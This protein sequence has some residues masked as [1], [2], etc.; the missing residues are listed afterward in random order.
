MWL[1]SLLHCTA[2]HF[3]A[4]SQKLL[5]VIVVCSK[6]NTALPRNVTCPIGDENNRLY[7]FFVLGPFCH[8]PT[9]E[10]NCREY[11]KQFLKLIKLCKNTGWRH[12][13]VMI[14]HLHL[15]RNTLHKSFSS[16]DRKD[17]TEGSCCSNLWGGTSPKSFTSSSSHSHQLWQLSGSSAWECSVCQLGLLFC[18]LLNAFVD[19]FTM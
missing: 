17:A 18:P 11:N 9:A 6:L 2:V 3:S 13:P 10:Q 7:F 1:C 8:L 12:Q 19:Y 15:V 4:S 5:E 16:A 14:L